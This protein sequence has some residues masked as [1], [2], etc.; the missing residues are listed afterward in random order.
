MSGQSAKIIL[1]REGVLQSWLKDGFTLGM[2]AALP[3]F[4][5]AYCGGSGWINM[6]IA[7]GW[8]FT[9][10]ARASGLRRKSEMTPAEARAWLDEHH[11]DREVA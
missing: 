4:N 5:H 10:F 6:A 2:L 11:P 3:W 1:L 9:V 8:F 7:F